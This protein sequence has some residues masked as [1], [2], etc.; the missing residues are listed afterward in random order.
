LLDQVLAELNQSGPWRYRCHYYYDDD[1]AIPTAGDFGIFCPRSVLFLQALEDC[2]RETRAPTGYPIF[3]GQV[4][5]GLT[6]VVFFLNSRIADALEVFKTPFGWNSLADLT[7]T[8]APLRIRHAAITRAD[9]VAV[10]IAEQM[11]FRRGSDIEPDWGFVVQSVRALERHVEEYGPSDHEVLRRAIGD[12]I[13]SA[14]LV[15]A[16]ERSIVAAAERLPSL[17]GTIVYPHD[18][19]LGVPVAAALVADRRRSGAGKA[20]HRLQRRLSALKPRELHRNALH[21]TADDFSFRGSTME[22]VSAQSPSIRKQIRWA[23]HADLKPLVLP[24]RRVVKG[25]DKESFPQFLQAVGSVARATKRGVDVC[26]LFDVSGSMGEGSKMAEAEAGVEA[27]LQLLQGANSRVC[28]ITFQSEARLVKPFSPSFRSGYLPGS[29]SPDGE[30]ALL[31]AVD[32]GINTLRR[33]GDPGHIWAIIG[34]TDGLENASSVRK[35]DVIHRLILSER[36]RVYGIA[37]GADADLD[38]YLAP[39][40]NASKGWAVRGDLGQIKALYGRVSTYV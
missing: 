6:P 33:D 7:R 5:F 11:S 16:Q 32:L 36:I 20:F 35:D 1:E 19:T 8:D 18:G 24:G 15:I 4:R 3:A 13:W 28:L 26:L 38:G 14:D 23:P 27:F 29:L 31:N 25:K 21:S 22:F 40:A 39:L 30:T 34:F 37:Y 9:G 17:E 10:S 12:G 2:W